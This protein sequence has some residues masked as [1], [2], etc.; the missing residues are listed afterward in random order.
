MAH[1]VFVTNCLDVPPYFSQVVLWRGK[2]KAELLG[3]KL[4]NY[5]IRWGKRHSTTLTMKHGAG[6]I[7]VWSC[8]A[9][10]GPEH[11]AVIEG[12]MNSNHYQDILQDNVRAIV[13]G[14]NI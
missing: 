3:R 12:I 2:T 14:L 9:S 8:F 1:C 11:F 4:Q 6:S 10:S 7:V 13:P 5:K